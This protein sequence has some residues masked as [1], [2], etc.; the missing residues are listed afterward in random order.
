MGSCWSPASHQNILLLQHKLS[1]LLG[2]AK[3]LQHRPRTHTTHRARHRLCARPARRAA[4]EPHVPQAGPAR[5]LSAA[6]PRPRTRTRTCCAQ[7]ARIHLAAAAHPCRCTCVRCTG[8][9]WHWRPTVCIK[10]WRNLGGKWHEK[11]SVSCAYKPGLWL[12]RIQDY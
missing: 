6:R 2:G 7:H 12:S 4:H 1:I 9:R 10:Y 11:M 5:G 8:S 3:P